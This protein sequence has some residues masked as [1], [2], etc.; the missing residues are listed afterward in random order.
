MR[1]LLIRRRRFHLS[2]WRDRY[3][4]A[5]HPMIQ[6]DKSI[7]CGSD[8]RVFDIGPGGVIA[9]SLPEIAPHRH[10]PVAIAIEERAPVFR[11]NAEC[12]TQM[13]HDDRSAQRRGFKDVKTAE[14]PRQGI[15]H[16]YPP[17][18]RQQ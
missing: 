5:S 18:S 1:R 9:E 16:R 15:E 14:R 2:G 3:R 13:A 11:G 4:S 6:T 12:T 8:N 7:Y 17:A 10:Y